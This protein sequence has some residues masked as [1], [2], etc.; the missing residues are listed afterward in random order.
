MRATALQPP[1]PTPI[2]LIRVPERASSSISYFKSSRSPS[3]IPTGASSLQHFS[4]PGRVL[5]L[6]LRLFLQLC[7]IHREARGGTPRRI[8][9]LV[10]P[11]HNPF[12]DSEARLAL[13]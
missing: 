12:G 13:Q 7:G 6:E 8:V 9:Q 4:D 5:L 11:I 3:I 2:T 1:P 10:G